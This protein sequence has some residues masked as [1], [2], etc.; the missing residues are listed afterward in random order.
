SEIVELRAADQRRQTVISE[1]LKADYRR[2]RQLVEALKIVKSLKTQMIELQTQQGPAE[3][4][5]P[6][7]AG[8]SSYTGIIIVATV[9]SVKYYGLFPASRL[10]RSFVLTSYSV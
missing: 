6:E 1:L 8:S 3:P 4:E 7:E 10:Y 5:L 9:Q 2:Q